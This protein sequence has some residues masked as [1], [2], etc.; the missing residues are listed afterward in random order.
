VDGGRLFT[1]HAPDLRAVYQFNTRAFVRLVLQYTRI[2]RD[3]ALYESEV[4]SEDESLLS[5]LLFSYKVN[6]QTALFLGY[7]DNREGD[8]AYDLT[9][10]QRMLFF[11]VGYAWVR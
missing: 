8:D 9:Q 2:S 11:K 3:P 4:G 5:Q 7:G 1:V 10:T 6:P